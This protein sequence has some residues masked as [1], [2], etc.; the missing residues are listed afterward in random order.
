MDYV[1]MIQNCLEQMGLEQMQ[2]ERENVL[3]TTLDKFEL[4]QREAEERELNM[5]LAA[6]H[7]YTA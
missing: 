7:C 3:A 1:E 5:R 2:E 6:A 4:K